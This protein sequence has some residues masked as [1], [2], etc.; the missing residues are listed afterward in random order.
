MGPHLGGPVGIPAARQSW[1]VP[2]LVFTTVIAAI[3]S[4]LGAPLIPSISTALEVPLGTAQWSLTAA[5][6]TGAVSA[7]ILG[8]LGDGPRRRETLIGALVAVTAG[9]VIAAL[10]PTLALL[11]VGRALQGIGLGLVPLTIAAARDHLPPE[12]A[13]GTIAL[14]A[15]C[16]AAGSGAGYPISGL[17]ADRAGVWAAFWFGAAFSGIALL[18]VVLVVPSSRARPPAGLDVLGATL[19][20]AGLVALLLAI[21][22]GDVWGWGSPLVIGLLVGALLVLTLWTVQQLRSRAPLVDL[23]L[24]RRPVVLTGD[25]CAVVLGIAMYMYISAVTAY[26]QTPRGAGYGFSATVVVA[27]LCLVPFSV[28]SIAASRAL[29]RLTQAVGPRALLP[30]GCLVVASGGAFFALLHSALWQ[31]FVMMGIVG[32]GF[33]LTFA[34]IPGIIVRAVPDSETGSAMGFYQVVRYIGFSLGSAL[35]GSILAGYTRAGEHLPVEDGF[36]VVL[37]IAVT[38]CVVAAVL[39]WLLPGRAAAQG[40]RGEELADRDAQL[41]SAGL[42]GLT[43]E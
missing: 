11:V 3:V 26:V 27:G 28:L 32:V 12:R 36:R 9:G 1:L 7:P 40:A 22:Q 42:I 25:G 37:W 4:S 6:L 5:L 8:R 20:S 19:L 43:R 10:A 24:L 17:I 35:T 2:V 31:A 30:I 21:A 14:L 23:R 34:A 41:G 15:V 13:P 39:A 33:G 18:C 16:A 38:V 29:P